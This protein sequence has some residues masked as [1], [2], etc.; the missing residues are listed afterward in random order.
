[1]QLFKI[2]LIEVTVELVLSSYLS[3][4][5]KDTVEPSHYNIQTTG[6]EV[7]LPRYAAVEHFVLYQHSDGSGSEAHSHN[8]QPVQ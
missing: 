1:M 2:N 5:D 7:W 4:N 6:R 8:G 3:L